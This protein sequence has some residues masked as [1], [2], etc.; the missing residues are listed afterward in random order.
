MADGERKGL[1]KDI[2]IRRQAPAVR[3]HALRVTS[4]EL[5]VTSYEL[6]VTSYEL[7]VARYELWR[8]N[9]RAGSAA[10]PF[11]SPSIA[12]IATLA[13]R[14]SQRCTGPISLAVLNGAAAAGWKVRTVRAANRQ[15]S[16]RVARPSYL[17]E[18]FPSQE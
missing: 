14:K 16:R 1:P 11:P 12:K 10:S 13:A 2:T 18:L 9:I 7:R 17:L 15:A 6:R 4:Y 5:R 8:M 3:E